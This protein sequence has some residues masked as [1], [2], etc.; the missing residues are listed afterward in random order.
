MKHSSASF[1]FNALAGGPCN[2]FGR[3]NPDGTL[4]TGFNPAPSSWVSNVALQPDGKILV[5]GSFS[6]VGGQP[7]A[8]IARLN[9]SGTADLSFNPGM[10]YLPCSLALQADGRIVVGGVFSTLGGQPR[11]NLGRLNADG[12]LDPSLNQGTDPSFNGTVY[13]AA[14]QTDGKILVAGNFATLAG[15]PRSRLGR[16]NSTDPATESLTCDATTITWLRGGVSPEV[17]RA[18]FDASADGINWVSL[19]TGTRISGGWQL[20]GIAVPTNALIRALGHAT[21]G[22]Y[23]GSAW[24]VKTILSAP[25]VFNQPGSQTNSPGSVATFSVV[26]GGVAPLSYQ[27]LKDGMVLPEGANASGTQTPALTLSNLARS[28]EGGYSVIITNSFGSVTSLVATLTVFDPFIV[29]SPASQ[30]ANAGDTVALSVTALGTAPLN[31]QWRKDGAPV[32]G[33]TD[34]SLTLTNMQRAEAGCY[35]VVVGNGFGSLTSAVAVLMVNLASIDAFD[36]NA[37]GTVYA[38][39]IQGDGKILVGGAFPTL[40]EQAHNNLGRLNVDGTL[41]TSFTA[42]ANG[43]VDTLAVQADGRILV[44]G[45][46]YRLSGELRESIGR[47]NSDGMVDT[48][49]NPG[50]NWT[51]YC[52]VPQADRKILVGG[53][54]TS[55]AGPGTTNIGRLNPDGTQDTTFHA[56]ASGTVYSLVVQQDGMILIGGAF[57]TL[58]GQPRDH[59]ARL[60]PDGSLDGTFDPGAGSTVSG[61]AIQADGKILVG[62]YFLTLGGQPRNYIGRL[63]ADGSLDSAFNPSAND[64][65]YSLAVQADGKIQVGG[66]FTMLGGQARNR[67]GRL[68]NDGTLDLTFNPGASACV[69]S[70]AQQTDG[71]TLVGGSFT[72]LGGQPRNGIGRLNN[73][74]AAVESLACE[75]ASITWLR[76]GSSPEL[77]QTVAEASTNGNDWVTLGTGARVTGGWQFTGVSVPANAT[78]RARGLATGGQYNRSSWMVETNIVTSL[79]FILTPPLSQTNDVGTDA[80]FAVVAG[81]TPPL[82][83]Q[84]CKNGTNITGA[85]ASS[86]ALT[87]VQP[88]D[89]ACYWVIVANSFGSITKSTAFLVVNP[90]G[91]QFTSVR[92]QANGAVRLQFTAPAGLTYLIEASSDLVHW[93]SIG[94]AEAQPDGTFAFEDVNAGEYPWRYYRVARL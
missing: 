34:T 77:S 3:L 58:N 22:R 29:N 32:A 26:A 1:R 85:T 60:Y 94:Q 24:T 10:D 17:A 28:D 62:G 57:T 65:V 53:A 9:S 23:N 7:R 59:L 93:E 27:W 73:P 30:N 80:A 39:A 88:A 41:D 56:N 47:L 48:N 55:L 64:F 44:G 13:S 74:E 21:G 43:T 52:L 61:L 15:Q 66:N 51:V 72:T 37:D 18:S 46:F 11:S 69:Y 2:Y 49:F 12:T 54:F 82:S 78:I 92:Y 35:D 84:W 67:M 75:A 40:G 4:D 81:G 31:Y 14:V 50:A 83:Y 16:F 6:A 76:S 89:Q 20:A 68:N 79:P 19:G 8:H 42:D 63:S 71:T 5:G 70:L 25:T 87:N 91:S 38:T 36:P 86:L 90:S 33:A 45:N